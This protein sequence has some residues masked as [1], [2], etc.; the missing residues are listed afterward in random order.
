MSRALTQALT[1]CFYICAALLIA[2]SLAYVAYGFVI[3]PLAIPC[4]VVGL[5]GSS[6]LR[7]RRR[8]Q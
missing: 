8:T 7:L 4:L 2:N 1:A 3:A 5:V 6:S